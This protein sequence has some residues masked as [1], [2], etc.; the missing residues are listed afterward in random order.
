[1]NFSPIE[2]TEREPTYSPIKTDNSEILIDDFKIE[3]FPVV[4]RNF[5]EHEDEQLLEGDISI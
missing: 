5:E 1:M 2:P 4:A 3:T